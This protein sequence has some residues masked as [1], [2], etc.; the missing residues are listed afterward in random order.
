MLFKK[1]I[2]APRSGLMKEGVKHSA[3]FRSYVR[4]ILRISDKVICQSESWKKFYQDIYKG[5]D[6]KFIVIL[7]WIDLH[8]YIDNN[9]VYNNKNDHAYKLLYL[10]WIE[11]YKGI[12]DL[13]EAVNLIKNKTPCLKV[14]IYGSGK[15]ER[16]AVKRCREPWPPACMCFQ[17]QGKPGSAF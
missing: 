1:I 13:I 9:P 3:F 11:E 10:G 5:N 6:S 7:N 4:F 8:E 17:R 2:F 14:E 12:F 15:A 16:R